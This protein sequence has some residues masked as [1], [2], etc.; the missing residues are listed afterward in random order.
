MHSEEFKEMKDLYTNSRKH[1][2]DPILSDISRTFT[3]QS[4]VE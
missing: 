2:S 1:F 4:L 3:E